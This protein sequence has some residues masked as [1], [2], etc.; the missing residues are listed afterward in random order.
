[1]SNNRRH[2]RQVNIQAV[3][4]MTLL[5]ATFAAGYRSGIEQSDEF[6]FGEMM[7]LI[8]TTVVPD[9][10]EA[11]GEPSNMTPYPVTSSGPYGCY[12]EVVDHLAEKTDANQNAAEPASEYAE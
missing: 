9:A 4:V 11:F 7:R 3:M 12:A 8:E 1:M 5:S 2:W 6:F 10:W